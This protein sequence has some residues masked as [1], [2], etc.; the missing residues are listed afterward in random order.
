MGGANFFFPE[1]NCIYGISS[2]Y[3]LTNGGD[4]DY[5]Y[6]VNKFPWFK[7]SGNGPNVANNHRMT[8]AYFIEVK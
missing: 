6:Y 7:E 1:S 3:F 8:G 2:S 4:I 5:E